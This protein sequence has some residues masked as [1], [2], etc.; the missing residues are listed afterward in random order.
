MLLVPVIPTRLEHL[1]RARFSATKLFFELDHRVAL[2]K[3]TINQVNY[4]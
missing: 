1:D 4:V 2:P 3:K